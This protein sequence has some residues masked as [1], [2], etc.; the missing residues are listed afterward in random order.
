MGRTDRRTKALGL[1]NVAPEVRRMMRR[2][3]L[4]QVAA[5]KAIDVSH[6]TVWFWLHGHKAMRPYADQVHKAEK[7][8]ARRAKRA[9]G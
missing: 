3:K 9:V 8:L 5:A 2:Y 1:V 6:M 4:T 7:R